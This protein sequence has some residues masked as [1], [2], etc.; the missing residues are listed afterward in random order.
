VLQAAVL[1]APKHIASLLPPGTS[2]LQATRAYLL[3]PNVGSLLPAGTS[4]LQATRACLLLLFRL[5]STAPI[6]GCCC[7][8]V[9]QLQAAD[10]LQ[11]IQAAFAA[12]NHAAADKIMPYLTC[13]WLHHPCALYCSCRSTQWYWQYHSGM[14]FALLCF[15]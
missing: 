9:E 7:A 15:F 8:A 5:S 4:F 14:A 10:A 12:A 2:V 11:L 13:A 6:T 1:Q 3:L